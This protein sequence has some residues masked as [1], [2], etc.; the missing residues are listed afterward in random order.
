[1]ATPSLQCTND[2]PFSTS[3]RTFS[4]S[5]SNF[6]MAASVRF[7]SF[8]SPQLNA[9]FVCP[10]SKVFAHFDLHF[11]LCT[12]RCTYTSRRATGFHA[13][14]CE[15]DFHTAE[16]NCKLYITARP[17]VFRAARRAPHCRP[18]PLLERG[19]PRGAG[20]LNSTHMHGGAKPPHPCA[21]CETW[22]Q[23]STDHTHK[24]FCL[25]RGNMTQTPSGTKTRRCAEATPN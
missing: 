1:M 14:H 11:L 12:S 8:P 4:Y 3:V 5:L 6:F 19:L 9:P 16:D 21:C 25:I 23:P 18:R 22:C 24:S 7:R 2:S 10:K 15:G 17:S 13:V 20:S